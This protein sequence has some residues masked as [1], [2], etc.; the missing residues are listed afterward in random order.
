MSAELYPSLYAQYDAKYERTL[1]ERFEAIKN[2]DHIVTVIKEHFSDLFDLDVLEYQIKE[3]NNGAYVQLFNCCFERLIDVSQPQ[4]PKLLYTESEIISELHRFFHEESNRD[5]WLLR[6]TTVPKVGENKQKQ[7]GY[8]EKIA[9]GQFKYAEPLSFLDMR[10]IVRGMKHLNTGRLLHA[11]KSASVMQLKH[12]EHLDDAAIAEL[13]TQDALIVNFNPNLKEAPQWGI[14]DLQ[15]RPHP[16]VFCDMPIIDTRQHMLEEK[17]AL[18]NCEYEGGTASSLQTTGYTA[19]SWLDENLFKVGQSDT[20][21]DFTNL[22]FD[23]TYLMFGGDRGSLPYDASDEAGLFTEAFK[24]FKTTVCQTSGNFSRLFVAAVQASALGMHKN[25]R[26]KPGDLQAL[27]KTLH[28]KQSTGRELEDARGDATKTF[29]VGFSKTLEH[30]NYFSQVKDRVTNQVLSTTLTVPDI[31]DVSR[32][33]REHEISADQQGVNPMWF[34]NLLRG[35][36]N[37]QQNVAV[38]MLYSLIRSKSKSPVI[39]IWVPGGLVIPTNDI[40]TIVRLLDQ[41]AFVTELNN[42]NNNRSLE[43]IKDRAAPTL[44]RNRWL[45]ASGYLPPIADDYWR[46]AAEYW[47]THLNETPDVLLPK[48]E[49]DLFKTCVG[50]MGPAGL[51]AVLERLRDEAYQEKLT[52]LYGLRKPPFYLGCDSAQ[53][54]HDYLDTFLD[55][56]THKRYFPFGEVGIA[57]HP[58]GF[59]IQL[60]NVLEALNKCHDFE[61]VTLTN[62]MDD[63]RALSGFLDVLTHKARTSAWQG[64]VIIPELQSGEV[65]TDQERVLRNKYALLNDIILQNKRLHK[66]RIA[67]EKIEASTTFVDLAAPPPAP[68]AFGF[69]G[70]DEH[71][72]GDLDEP[73]DVS[74]LAHDLD[75]I[76]RDKKWPFK[77]GGTV[78]LQLQQQQEINQS[79]QIQQEKQRVVHQIAEAALSGQLVDYQNIDTILGDFWDEFKLENKYDVAAAR[80]KTHTESEL[81]GFF[82]TF[83]NANPNV[84]DAAHV[85]QKMTPAAA[86]MLLKHHRHLASGLNP[87][88]LPRGFFTQRAKDGKLVLLYDPEL[89]YLAL[90]TAFTLDFSVRP[91]SGDAWEGSFR[92]L[93]L[94]LYIDEGDATQS[95]E[96]DIWTDILLFAKLQPRK[97]RAEYEAEY[98]AFAG[99]QRYFSDGAALSN[100]TKIL[101]NWPVF[102]QCWKYAG[103]D[104]VRQFLAKGEGEFNFLWQDMAFVLFRQQDTLLKE[105]VYGQAQFNE[106]E[107]RAMGQVYYKFGNQGLTCCLRKL[108]ELNDVLGDE[109]F[110]EFR[111][112]ILARTDNFNVLMSEKCVRALDD[113]IVTLRPAEAAGKKQ[114][115]INVMRLHMQSVDW[116]PVE[117]LWGAFSNFSNEL[118]QLSGIELR[119]DEFSRIQ[120][121]NMLVCMDRIVGSLEHLTEDTQQY[122]LRHLHEMDL[123]HGGVHHALQKEGFQNF[124]QDLRLHDFHAGRPTYAADLKRL[125]E[126]DFDLLQMQRALAASSQFKPE[127]FNALIPQFAVCDEA[128]KDKLMW[129]LNT[130]YTILENNVQDILD[131]IQAV[132][133]NIKSVIATHLQNAVY[134]RGHRHLVVSLDAL[135][136]ALPFVG[137]H[138]ALSALLSKHP[139][140]TVLEA[141]TILHQTQ[142]LTEEGVRTLLV[143]FDADLVKPDNCSEVLSGKGYKLAVLFNVLDAGRMQAFYDKMQG[144]MPIVKQELNLLMAQLLSA[145]CERGATPDINPLTHLTP[146]KFD[147][148]LVCIDEMQ[149]A[150]THMSDIR[151]AMLDELSA[152]GI[153]FKYSK[154]GA[155]REVREDEKPEAELKIFTDHKARLWAFIKEHIVVPSEGNTREELGPIFRFLKRLQ[156][157]R[158]YL[159]EVEPLLASLEKTPGGLFWT[160]RFFS[161][162]LQALQPETDDVSF[163]ISLLKVILEERAICARKIDEVQEAFPDDL[164]APFQTIL[165]ATVFDRN[166]QALLCRIA[167]REFGER[168]VIALLND[169]MSLLSNEAYENSRAYALK[170]LV[171]T[172]SIDKLEQQFLNCRW[173]LQHPSTPGL[174]GTWTEVGALWLKALS[175]DKNEQVLFDTIKGQYDDNPE[176]QA[177][178]LHVIAF[179]SLREG[180]KDT[181]IQAYELNKKAPKLVEQLGYMPLDELEMLANCYPNQPSPGTDDIRRLLKKQHKEGA[182][183][184]AC[185]DDFLT[186]PYPDPRADYA[187]VSLTRDAD[188]Q[189]MIAET[190]VSAAEQKQSFPATTSANLTLVFMYLKS[191]EAGDLRIAG[192]D[193]AIKAMPQEALAEAFRSLS[194]KVKRQPDDMSLR[195]QVWAVLFEVLGRTTKK[196]PHLAQQFALIANDIGI[197]ASTRVLQLAT[198]EGKSHFVSM[199]AARHV[200]QGKKVDVCT[201]KRTLAARDL[202]DYDDFFKYL[203]LKTACVDS[204]LMKLSRENPEEAKAQYETANICYSTVGDLS[205]F[206]DGQTYAG[207]AIEHDPEQHVG[208]FDEFDFIRFEEGRK[209]EY[210]FARPTGKTPKQMTWFYQAVNDFYKSNQFSGKKGEPGERDIPPA[211]NITKAILMDFYAFLQ[212]KAEGDEE[213]GNILA[214]IREPMQ[215][216]QW[217]QSA[218]EAYELERGSGFTV[219]E[220]NISVGDEMYPM[221]EVIPVS[222]DNQPMTDST[223]SAGVHQLLAVRLNTEAEGKGEPQNFHIHPESNIISSQVA[224]RLMKTLWGIWEGFSGTITAAQA[225]TLHD[226]HGTEVLHVPT[227]QRDLRCWHK[228]EFYA[229]E[230]ARDHRMVQQIRE[231]LAKKQSILFACKDDKHV[232]LLE[233]KL[234]GKEENGRFVGGLLTPEECEQFIFHTNEK[235]TTAAE[236]LKE[237]TTKEAWSGGKKQQAIGLVASG[238]GRGDNPAVEAVFLFGVN[239]TS[240]KLQRGGR[241]ARNGEEGEVFQFYLNSELIQEEKELMDCVKKLSASADEEDAHGIMLDEGEDDSTL[242]DSAPSHQSLDSIRENLKAVVADTP[243]EARFERLML[244][245]E[246]IFSFQNAANQGYRE[247]VAEFSAWGMKCLGQIKDPGKR[248]EFTTQYSAYLKRL[249]KVWINILSNKSL[250][251]DQKIEAI[252]DVVSD[253]DQGIA[254]AFFNDLRPGLV[255]ADATN[256]AQFEFLEAHEPVQVELVVPPKARQSTATE[257]A[258][259]VICGAMARLSGNMAHPALANVPE[260]IEELERLHT[261]KC[262]ALEALANEDDEADEALEGGLFSAWPTHRPEDAQERAERKERQIQAIWNRPNAKLL[263]LAE[264]VAEC[265]TFEDFSAALGRAVR[266]ARVPSPHDEVLESATQG[267][268]IADLLAEFDNPALKQAYKSVMKR[269]EPALQTEITTAL[270]APL[271]QGNNGEYRITQAMPL[272]NYLAG[273][274]KVE[275]ERWGEGYVRELIGPLLE[276]EHAQVLQQHLDGVGHGAPIPM[277]YNHFY[278]LWQVAKTMTGEMPFDDLF[279]LLGDAV[280]NDPENRL[281]MLGKWELWAKDLSE[282]EKQAFLISFCKTMAQF[283]EGRNWDVFVGLVKKTQAWWNKFGTDAYRSEIVSLWKQLEDAGDTLQEVTDFLDLGVKP[284]VREDAVEL[285]SEADEADEPDAALDKQKLVGI[286]VGKSWFQLLKLGFQWFDKGRLIDHGIQLGQL[287]RALD[288]DGRKKSVRT[289]LF[290]R[291]C[292]GLNQTYD[293]FGLLKGEGHEAHCKQQLMSLDGARFENFLLFVHKQYDFLKD[294]LLVLDVALDYLQDKAIPVP[295]AERAR[296]VFINRVEEPAFDEAKVMQL[297]VTIDHFRPQL[298]V[299][300]SDAVFEKVMQLTETHKQLFAKYPELHAKMF[301][302]SLDE[303]VTPACFDHLVAL[304][305]DVGAFHTLHPQISIT[306]L[307]AGLDRSKHKP[308]KVLMALRDLF[309]DKVCEQ[310]LFDNAAEYLADTK[311]DVVR[312][313]M[314]DVM[315][316]F[317]Q[318]RSNARADTIGMLSAPDVHACFRFEADEPAEI[319]NK[320]VI[321]MHLLDQGVWIEQ[322]DVGDMAVSHRFDQARNNVLLDASYGRYTA[323]TSTLLNASPATP[324]GRKV[325]DLTTTQQTR[326]LKLTDEFQVIGERCARPLRSATAV[327]AQVTALKASLNKVSKTYSNSW[328]KSAERSTQFEGLNKKI[329]RCLS[330]LS[331]KD[332]KA[333]L[334]YELVLVEIRAARQRAMASDIQVNKSRFFK[335][336]S[337]GRSRYFNTLN[338]MEDAILRH[339]TK[340]LEAVQ[341]FSVYKAHHSEEFKDV[342]GYLNQALDAHIKGPGRMSSSDTNYDSLFN[343][344]GRF[345][346]FFTDERAVDELKKAIDAFNVIVDGVDNA[347]AVSALQKDLKAVSPKLPGHLQTLANEMLARSEALES[348]LLLQPGYNDIRPALQ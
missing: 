2:I 20:E 137:T 36:D 246:Y 70:E 302:Y 280:K 205:L 132:N 31:I 101:D 329:D 195:A 185:L 92:Q 192:S 342:L 300:L 233:E 145:D 19:T 236:V 277:D 156:L 37:Q 55:H 196:Y 110:A 337:G 45:H 9:T 278:A 29:I 216:V 107:L 316:L 24:Y 51:A 119:G 108:K 214:L 93:N 40:E 155:F 134:E 149:A 313:D 326:L 71:K 83:I 211:A 44:A 78:Q 198:G 168:G 296:K 186:E 336:N 258:T 131:R 333:S 97:T 150:P 293:L 99:T 167:L 207:Y 35:D 153:Q 276:A 324:S 98:N 138:Q 146:D 239:D 1:G 17:L 3:G 244:L 7:I 85:I 264:E 287:W 86:K 171:K 38:F 288:V 30:V 174:R 305:L 121:E 63:L 18:A 301:E 318:T 25:E 231:C 289:K 62:G 251:A 166:Q 259:A 228:P 270:C 309:A 43:H 295:R 297:I 79:R 226:D 164:V 32:L 72:E 123:T 15:H 227:N 170:V 188:L 54:Y 152:D 323:H 133:P 75:D 52:N 344:I 26:F 222:S 95:L 261:Q 28:D 82:H 14:L 294:N 183:W 96:G 90:P 50:E 218:R 39:N 341:Q 256:L 124:H 177:L 200:G 65:R 103:D 271:I 157:N 345:F 241:T 56:L 202:E 162:F 219:R 215:L 189:R 257:K 260:M 235:L 126:A 312:T 306:H 69:G 67:L 203:G 308:E 47:L 199:R 81:K 206:L 242:S 338:Q 173:L 158:T 232:N 148:F 112:H 34:S 125:Y 238:F 143:L 12:L 243:E 115:F 169:V 60:A 253:L 290:S 286:F 217:L 122:L 80:L 291:C 66:S 269:F 64:L 175:G 281:R 8:F 182:S 240:D 321:F 68:D 262:L 247:V 197:E 5:D 176:R 334:P 303:A 91:L 201:A 106:D 347:T 172:S 48:V 187:G 249:E 254:P 208:L 144:L 304:L 88:N 154:S 53:H 310:P 327:D 77:K 315:K 322:M 181:D 282:D 224:S 325:R 61:Q 94:E 268:V 116:E 299:N 212:D 161:G 13:K 89:S 250:A 135:L 210:N 225:K 245:R 100:K 104:G 179:S 178:I 139:N 221:R 194:E 33:K 229:E 332:A 76:D 10:R 266:Q 58:G 42:V 4:Q 209:T 285:D 127:A 140:G 117:R 136:K 223:F 21:A 113:M 105:W 180:L 328:F 284:P 220:L 11:T 319:R 311:R 23:T 317:Y 255:G 335:M 193:K 292:E 272:L 16:R 204:N 314:L 165:K 343:R 87:D 320:R 59:D 339:W 46:R 73:I 159:N 160:A 141:L 57:Y 130:K 151:I 213:K 142:R 49:H 265:E 128:A 120:P 74:A 6:Y 279:V 275:Q 248:A 109:F 118:N 348:N 27:I 274:S 346:G 230:R 111:Q 191:L 298:F 41:N 129:L 283:E 263:Q 237:K 184:K 114:A 267:I 102:Y 190:R 331:G 273:F 252:R 307:L 22:L 163:P 234:K 84:G 147:R 330:D 340:D